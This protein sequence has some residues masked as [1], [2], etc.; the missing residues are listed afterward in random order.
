[1]WVC[2]ECGKENDKLMVCSSCGFDESK[3]YLRYPVLFPMD[4]ESTLIAYSCKGKINGSA[5]AFNYG[6]QLWSQRE[7]RAEALHYLRKAANARNSEACVFLSKH[8][9]ELD[10]G[11][12]KEGLCWA[13]KAAK[14]GDKSRLQPSLKTLFAC[15]ENIESTRTEMSKEEMLLYACRITLNLCWSTDPSY[16]NFFLLLKVCKLKIN[17]QFVGIKNTDEIL[18]DEYFGSMIICAQ[19]YC[20]YFM[21]HATQKMETVLRCCEELAALYARLGMNKQQIEL[22]NTAAVLPGG[23]GMLQYMLGMCYESG[24]GVTRNKK[25]MK[26]WFRE[27]SARGHKEA[28]VKVKRW[29]CPFTGKLPEQRHHL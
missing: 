25:K 2:A 8:I 28:E 23:N 24:T 14:Y 19:N 3:N 10:R 29:W 9:M 26:Y 7:T 21:E 13:L 4:I 27:A 16:D 12:F 17:E 11:Y 6:K 5:D 15:F 22:L 1:M 20:N 18:K